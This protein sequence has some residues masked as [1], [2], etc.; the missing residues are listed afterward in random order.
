MSGFMN[1]KMIRHIARLDVKGQDLIKGVHLEGLRKVGNPSEAAEDYYH[2]GADELIYIDLVASL[3]GRSKLTEIVRSTTK[4]VFIPVTVG[5]GIRSC[6]DVEELLQ[7]G[8]DKIAINTAIV[9][10]PNLITEITNR[11]GSQCL[12]ASIEA[13]FDSNMKQWKV[14]TDCAREVTNL[15]VI[16]WAKRCE[17]MGAGEIL[18]TSV[19]KEGTRKGFDVELASAVTA[20][21]NIPVIVSGGFGAKNHIL[22][23]NK[24]PI[25]A[26]AFADALH[27][28]RYSMAEIKAFSQEAGFEVRE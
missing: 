8:A 7:A 26:L 10:N 6:K 4:K 22:D 24:L 9:Q 27:F 14:L 16:K 17:S 15:E 21:V 19:D 23:I 2:Q 12:V 20:E 25:D 28:K 3:Y 11:F 1:S 5:G 18:L 13:K